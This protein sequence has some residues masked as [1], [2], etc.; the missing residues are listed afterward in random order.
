MPELPEVETVRRSMA[1]RVVGARIGTVTFR[2]F[3]GVVGDMAPDMFSALV[4]GERF[5][6][7]DRRGK[8]LWLAFDEGNGLFIHLM[9]TGQL[10]RAP[11]V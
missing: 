11:P 7:I 2:E 8:H 1:A 6:R 10:M 4:V 5:N 3:P 9:M